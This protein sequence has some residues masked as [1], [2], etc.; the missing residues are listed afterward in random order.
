MQSEEFDH[1]LILAFYSDFRRFENALRKAGYSKDGHPAQA[2]W[3]RFLKAIEA[4]FDPN[5][6][7]EWIGAYLT[8]LDY[9]HQSVRSRRMKG[10][11][12][13]IVRVSKIIQKW[14]VPSSN[15][16]CPI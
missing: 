8:L 6:K 3:D 13:E 14:E 16:D 9:V 2:D 4:R 11:M 5:A 1:D 15:P 12:H 10:A 7:P